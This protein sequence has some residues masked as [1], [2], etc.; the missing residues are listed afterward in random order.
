[1]FYIDVSNSLFINCKGQLIYKVQA[2]GAQ[3][4]VRSLAYIKAPYL[5][6]LNSLLKYILFIC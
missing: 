6:D 1:M 2:T 3:L 4:P 5:S